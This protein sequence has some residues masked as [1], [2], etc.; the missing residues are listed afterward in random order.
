MDSQAPNKVVNEWLMKQG[1]D[2][3]KPEFNGR[4]AADSV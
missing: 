3:I 1:Y 2:C 4:S